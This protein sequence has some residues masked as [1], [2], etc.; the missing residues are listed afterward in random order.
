MRFSSPRQRIALLPIAAIVLSFVLPLALPPPVSAQAGVAT[1]IDTVGGDVSIQRGD[2]NATLAAVP[3]AP[4]LTGDY[5][6][7]GAQ[8][9]AEVGFDS[10]SAVR[11]GENVQM[12]FADVNPA[13]RQLQL[14]AGAIDVRLFGDGDAPSTVDTPSISVVPRTA[15]SFRIEVDANGETAVTVRAGRADVVTP[16]GNQS[17]QPG[18]TL[19]ADG[20]AAN[21]SIHM[22]T[23]IA[24]D[25]FDAYN[26]ER[27][28]IYIAATGA[29]ATTA[30]P[31]L[32][33]GAYANPNTNAY[34]NTNTNR[35]PPPPSIALQLLWGALGLIYH[36]VAPAAVPLYRVPWERFTRN[37]GSYT[38]R[39]R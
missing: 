29:R 36:P 26:G 23:A 5:L 3:N 8:S 39:E 9:R 33:A 22:Q 6:I 35:L 31:Y 15:G 4:V 25:D 37:R 18:T 24:L 27:D 32:N 11:L 20:P 30:G 17:L 2:D 28:R 21:P 19:I 16:Q 14:A 34:A 38:H 1:R 12:R 10:R 13:N 7:T